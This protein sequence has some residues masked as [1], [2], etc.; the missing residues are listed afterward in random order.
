MKSLAIVGGAGRMGQALAEGL[1]ATGRFTVAALVDEQVPR[2]LFG[3]RHA[4]SLDELDAG[5]I[6]AVV[7]FSSPEGVARSATWCAEHVVAL[8]V[9]ATGLSDEQRQSLHDTG[10][11]VSVVVASNFSVGAILTERFA[12]AAAPYFDRVEIVELHHDQKVD[13]PSGTSLATARQIADA[14]RAAHQAPLADRT[15]R[16]TVAGSRGADGADG[17]KIHS[18]R[19]PGLVAHQ[20]VL[21]GSPGEGLTIR[22]DSFD[23]QSFVHGVAVALDAV[24][25]TPKFIDGISS[26]II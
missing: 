1:S 16:F 6:D 5:S 26:L 8:V 10:E 23:R 9:G 15:T 24:D 13:A 7:D 11:R 22:H 14:R 21:F 17:V 12:A 2:E 4:R 25:T 19:L 20:E 3:A 18:V